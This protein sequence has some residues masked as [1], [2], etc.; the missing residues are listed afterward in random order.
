[1]KKE[2]KKLDVVGRGLLMVMIPMILLVDPDYYTV[3]MCSRAFQNDWT[4]LS[5]ALI[6]CSAVVASVLS[7]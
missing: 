7:L 6:I 5:L 2:E 3:R 1:M 4:L